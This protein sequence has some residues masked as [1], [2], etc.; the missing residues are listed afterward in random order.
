MFVCPDRILAGLLS[1]AIARGSRGIGLRCFLPGAST[2][3]PLRPLAFAVP[4]APA[5]LDV[6]AAPPLF[7]F[8]GAGVRA[9]VPD[10]GSFMLV[11][12]PVVPAVP[13]TFVT[14]VVS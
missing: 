5:P 6:R 2:T 13:V 11:V 10:F 8:G 4:A 12:L 3:P 1:A 7:A 14:L 9:P